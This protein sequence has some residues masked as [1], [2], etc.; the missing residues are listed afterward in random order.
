[1]ASLAENDGAPQI[2]TPSCLYSC[3]IQLRETLGPCKNFA[4][5]EPARQQQQQQQQQLLDASC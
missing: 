5:E 4:H 1:M 3:Y 2:A